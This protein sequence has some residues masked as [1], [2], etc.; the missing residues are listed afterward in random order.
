MVFHDDLVRVFVDVADIPA[1]R[2]FFVQLK[3]RLKTRFRQIEIWM[4]TYPV[5]VV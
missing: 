3:E 1:H 5:D 2:E 4:T